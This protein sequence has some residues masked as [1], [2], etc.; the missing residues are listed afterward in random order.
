MFFGTDGNAIFNR[1]KDCKLVSY[2][3]VLKSAGYNNL[4]YQ[5]LNLILQELVI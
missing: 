5:V 4:F 3:K 1:V 2:A